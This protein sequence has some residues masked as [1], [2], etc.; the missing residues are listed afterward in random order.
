MKGRQAG[1]PH[2]RQDEAMLAAPHVV[3]PS[4]LRFGAEKIPFQYI[5][6]SFRLGF[7]IG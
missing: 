1:V 3:A 2:A 6:D 4:L 7:R 5:I